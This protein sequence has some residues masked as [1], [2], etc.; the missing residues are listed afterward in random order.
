MGL[1]QARKKRLTSLVSGESV[2][3]MAVVPEEGTGIWYF[4]A[5][6]TILPGEGGTGFV[7][8]AGKLYIAQGSAASNASPAI[9]EQFRLKTKLPSLI[10]GPVGVS[11]K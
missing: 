1:K 3:L 11:S 9:V 10:Y 4:L 8:E 5:D 7:D 2:D 6:C